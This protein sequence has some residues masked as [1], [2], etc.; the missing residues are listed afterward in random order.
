MLDFVLYFYFFNPLLF[1]AGNSALDPL[2]KFPYNIVTLERIW[3]DD[4]IPSLKKLQLILSTG[5][6]YGIMS[7]LSNFFPQ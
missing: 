6:C 4:E 2:L 1:V 3:C 5:L 7:N